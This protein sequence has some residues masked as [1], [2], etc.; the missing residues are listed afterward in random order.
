[1]KCLR[2]AIYAG[3]LMLFCAV[4]AV[5]ADAWVADWDM[6]N[7][8]AELR[9]GN[10]RNALMFAA[11]F[12]RRDRPFLTNDMKKA[13]RGGLASFLGPGQ[14]VF[15]SVVN[16]VV[17]APGKSVQKDPDLVSRLMATDA[18]RAAHRSDLLALLAVYPFAGLE[19]DYEKVR[20]ED[21]PRL[22]LFAQELSSTLAAQGKKLR[23][24]MEPRR[25]YL[26]GELP[27]GPQYVVMAYN[28]HGGHS[29]PGAKADDAFLRQLAQ[30][31]AHWPVKPGLALSAGGF[32]WTPRGVA[33]LTERKAVAWAQGAGVQP[34]R[35]AASHALYFKAADNAPGSPLLAK[36]GTTG[37][38]CEIWYAD[39]ETLARWAALGRSL[40]FG[41][42]S[43]WRL[44]GNMP[45][46]LE[47]IQGGSDAT[48]MQ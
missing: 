19:L 35:D 44:G 38:L 34:R 39:G 4:P 33:D 32:A 14:G 7:G 28:L 27:D 2:S 43:L 5:A 48:A 26:Q 1:M 18:S 9:Q 3:L 40:G 37:A 41:D 25:K 36:G 24:V 11:Y 12:D 23:L 30:W 31:C 20:M 17:E 22:L 6:S 45:E 42:V 15:L 13:L 8:L 46:S 47:K 10:F 29:G 16:D 21:W